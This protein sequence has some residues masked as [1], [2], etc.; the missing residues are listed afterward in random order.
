MWYASAS[1]MEFREAFRN[2]KKKFERKKKKIIKLQKKWN[3]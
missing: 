1:E 2:L 3:T